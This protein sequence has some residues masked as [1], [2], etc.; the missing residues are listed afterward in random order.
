MNKWFSPK[1]NINTKTFYMK[2][3]GGNN[4]SVWDIIIALCTDNSCTSTKDISKFSVDWR[5]QIISVNNC[6]FYQDDNPTKCKTREGC[7][8]YNSENPTTCDQ[9]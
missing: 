8:I 7:S 3:A 5:T 2:E 4:P 9:Y 1:S 6:K